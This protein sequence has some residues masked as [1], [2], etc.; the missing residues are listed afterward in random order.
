MSQVT[1]V[2]LVITLGHHDKNFMNPSKGV[3]LKGANE[4][5]LGVKVFSHMCPRSDSSLPGSVFDLINK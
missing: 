4:L 1:L 2:I 5:S 3:F